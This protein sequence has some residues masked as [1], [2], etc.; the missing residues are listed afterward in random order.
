MVATTPMWSL[1]PPKPLQPPSSS[2]PHHHGC[3]TL[4][5]RVRDHGQFT[6]TRFVNEAPRSHGQ[7]KLAI[8]D[9]G[10]PLLVSLAIGSSSPSNSVFFYFFSNPRIWDHVL[11][12]WLSSLSLALFSKSPDLAI[13]G[14]THSSIEEDEVEDK[15]T[16]KRRQSQRQTEEDE[17]EDEIWSHSD[18]RK[19][20]QPDLEPRLKQ[21]DEAT[22]SGRW[23]EDEDEQTLGRRQSWRRIE[24]DDGKSD[25]IWMCSWPGHVK[26]KRWCGRRRNK[27]GRERKWWNE[28]IFIF[29]FSPYQQLCVKL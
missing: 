26:L 16:N 24:E 17:A 12:P 23:P 11:R 9:D 2:P 25:S 6:V 8:V 18:S 28:R 15:Q 4:A 3:C 27:G 29:Y 5:V 1:P 22:K 14:Q 7:A 13:H 19:P 10:R 20:K 21:E